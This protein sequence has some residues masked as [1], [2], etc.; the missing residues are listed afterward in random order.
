[1]Y[2]ELY[3]KSISVAFLFFFGTSIRQSRLEDIIIHMIKLECQTLL[4]KS[5]EKNTFAEP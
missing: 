4:V 5:V 2:F 1:M 3:L